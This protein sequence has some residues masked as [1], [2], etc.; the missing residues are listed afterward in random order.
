VTEAAVK[1]MSAIEEAEGIEDVPICTCDQSEELALALSPW[2]KSHCVL[3]G[4]I[5]QSP[6]RSYLG[7][8]ARKRSSNANYMISKAAIVLLV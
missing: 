6:V 5:L 8:T 1:E 3:L 4:C 2:R 7:V